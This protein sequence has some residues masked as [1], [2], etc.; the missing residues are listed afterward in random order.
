L[1]VVE[2]VCVRFFPTLFGIIKVLP[3]RSLS[4]SAPIL[5]IITIIITEDDDDHRTIINVIIIPIMIIIT[6]MIIMMIIIIIIIIIIMIPF[7]IAVLMEIGGLRLERHIVFAHVISC[8][9]KLQLKKPL[10]QD[11]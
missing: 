6:I 7:F 9:P 5:P 11:H 10:I 2:R 3:V 1:F 8:A 4:F